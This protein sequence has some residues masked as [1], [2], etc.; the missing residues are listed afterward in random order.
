MGSA[1]ERRH[2]NIMSSLIGWAHTQ[3]DSWLHGCA[4]C[5]CLSILIEGSLSRRWMPKSIW[6][7]LHRWP[8]GLQ[9]LCRGSTTLLYTGFNITALLYDDHITGLVV[10]YG[11]SNTTV[12]E[13]PKL[14]TKTAIWWCNGMERLFAWLALCEW[15]PRIH[16]RKEQE[17]GTLMFALLLAWTSCWTNGLGASDV[18][19]C[20]SQVTSL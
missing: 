6:P 9:V 15:N 14:T 20:D 19:G 3:H 12:L 10:N 7:L 13:I 4:T 5:V 2:H 1:K 8:T 11:I 17:Y 16:L 18:G